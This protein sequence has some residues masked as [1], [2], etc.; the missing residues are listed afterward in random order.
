MI[1]RE[2]TEKYKTCTRLLDEGKYEEAVTLSGSISTAELRAAILI[3]GG[4]ALNKSGKVREGTEILENLI[5]SNRLE[6][7]FTR[8]SLFY[9]A[10]NGRSSLYTLR[11]KRR[12]NTIPTN[13]DDLR[14]AKKL[15]R[16]ALSTLDNTSGS[17]VSQVLTNYGNCLS[18]LGRFVEAIECYQKALDA[19]P[20]HGMAAGNLAIELEHA[21][22]IT[23]HYRHEYV[24]LAHD[25]I[26]RSLSPE[27]H[28]VSDSIGATQ[29][30]QFI[31][32]RLEHF[33][34]A[35]TEPILPPQP[36]KATARTKTQ[37]EYIQFCIENNLLLTP[38][39][40]N[41][42]LSPKIIDDIAFGPII[43]PIDD[44]YLVPE[45]LQ[46]LNEIKESFG[47][48][49]YIYYLS[50]REDKII[51]DISAM[52]LYFGTDTFEI[53]GLYGGL[54]KTAYSRAFDVLDK[55]ARITNIY[56]NIGKREDSF[57]RIY[58]EKQS[59]G[60][61]GT[62]RFVA[63]PAIYQINNY[64]LYALADLCID[65][66]ESE[67]V[68]LKIVDARRNRITHDYLNVRLHNLDEEQGESNT[69]ELDDL[70]HQTKDVLHLAKYAILYAVSAV[71]VA[72]MRK[73]KGSTERVFERPVMTKS[74]QPFL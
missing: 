37:K 9:N 35:H 53:N 73:A 50:Q 28:L 63:R 62:T 30:F 3:D 44:E 68:D 21:A 11:R 4:F 18:Q 51:D 56:F 7:D 61:T 22:R 26:S 71:N 20:S 8:C 69:I 59:L 41:Q 25:L 38:W 49:R 1:P 5:S 14:A 23:G 24:G 65:Y 70:Y 12:K 67:H 13:D 40:G 57:W 66:F 42:E 31:K 17:F 10:A 39:V 19:D 15:Y 64:G 6:S 52:T 32:D 46:I 48:A 74:G 33:I 72:E 29:D 16:D 54:C 27:M 60:Q 34:N 2:D 45:L 43:T 58:A 36:A 47:T 55:T